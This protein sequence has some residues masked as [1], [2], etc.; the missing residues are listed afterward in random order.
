LYAV[1]VVCPVPFDQGTPAA[2]PVR[3]AKGLSETAWLSKGLM[4]VGDG[5]RLTLVNVEGD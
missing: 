5:D 2:R 4:P 3:K 1:E